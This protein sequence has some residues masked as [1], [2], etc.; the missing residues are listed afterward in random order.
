MKKKMASCRPLGGLLAPLS[1][2]A[3]TATVGQ[4]L[5]VQ[6]RNGAGALWVWK[7]EGP[8]E[9]L[10]VSLLGRQVPLSALLAAGGSCPQTPF[11]SFCGGRSVSLA[12]REEHRPP[13]TLSERQGGHS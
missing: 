4:S 5:E 13:H 11:L 8:A 1:A 10:P 2:H 7:G 6:V 12:P 9:T 3:A